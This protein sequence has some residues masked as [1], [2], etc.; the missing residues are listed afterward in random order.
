M[1]SVNSLQKK[2]KSLFGEKLEVVRTHQQQESLKFMSHFKRKF[3]I[4]LGKRKTPVPAGTAPPVEFYYLR[5]NGGP[6]CTRLIQ[7]QPDPLALNSAFWLVFSTYYL[8]RVE[9]V[10]RTLCHLIVNLYKKKNCNNNFSFFF[11]LHIEGTI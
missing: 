4:H 1:L 3:V 5:S 7:I 8:L 6:L 2:F 9:K 10:S 11:K